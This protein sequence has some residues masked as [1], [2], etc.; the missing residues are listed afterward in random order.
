MR[1]LL[2]SNDVCRE[3]SVWPQISRTWARSVKRAASR[4]DCAPAHVKWTI[5]CVMISEVEFCVE[6]SSTL[7]ILDL[8]AENVWMEDLDDTERNGRF[9]T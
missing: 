4:Q 5:L 6:H 2:L 3:H 7:R 8:S 9:W 1:Q